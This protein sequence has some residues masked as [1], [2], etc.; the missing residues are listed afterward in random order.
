MPT[1]IWKARRVE[2]DSAS[3]SNYIDNY[4]RDY[5]FGEYGP[6]SAGIHPANSFTFFNNPRDISRVCSEIKHIEGGIY[7]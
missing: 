6:S 7:E 1:G 4:I 2:I 5:L 3:A